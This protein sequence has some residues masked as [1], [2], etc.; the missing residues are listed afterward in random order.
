MASRAIHIEVAE[1]L[2]TDSFISGL[3][4]FGCLRGPICQL[5]SD[6]GTNFVGAKRELKEALDELDHTRI[7]NELQCHN[8][9][10]FFFNMNDPSASHMGGSLE[11]KDLFSP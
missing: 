4:K 3:R 11:T 5:R 1:T 9:H 6:Q 7:R 2:E 10:W 8:C